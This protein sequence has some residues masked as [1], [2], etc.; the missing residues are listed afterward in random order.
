MRMRPVQGRL[1]SA[2]SC[3]RRPP[4]PTAT[5]FACGQPPGQITDTTIRA[6]ERAE[7]RASDLRKTREARSVALLS[8]AH[9]R[10]FGRVEN[11]E[12]EE[13]P[14]ASAQGGKRSDQPLRE[15]ATPA[16]S[17]GHRA[18][19]HTSHLDAASSPVAS[20]KKEKE[21]TTT[22]YGLREF[23]V[24]RVINERTFTVCSKR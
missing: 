15:R 4:S 23:A 16:H 19:L 6:A 5:S 2:C 21:K 12:P 18:L 3:R 14:G 13:H 17:P 8:G 22:V 11:V 7:A 20:V 1:T 24:G 9:R 10:A